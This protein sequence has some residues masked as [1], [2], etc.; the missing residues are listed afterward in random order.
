MKYFYFLFIAG[1][2]FLSS[3]EKGLQ[4]K[5]TEKVE[6]KWDYNTVLKYKIPVQDTSSRFD[7]VAKV[8]H[9]SDFSYQNFYVDLSTTFPDG[10]T[11]SDDVSFQLTDGMGSWQGKCSSSSCD[12]DLLLQQRFRFQQLGDYEIQIKNNSRE[13]LEGIQQIELR[14]YEVAA[15]KDVQ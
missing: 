8:T 3:C 9:S 11:L 13:E 15:K 5:H 10:K 14:L 4:Y 2:L 12:V 6:G 1:I 7:L